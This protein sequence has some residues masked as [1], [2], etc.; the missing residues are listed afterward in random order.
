M[1][2]LKTPKTLRI[3]SIVVLLHA[4][5]VVFSQILVLVGTYMKER[6][7][8]IPEQLSSYVVFPIYFLLPIFILI[9]VY[10]SRSLIQKKYNYLIVLWLAA[11]SVLYFAFGGELY[12]FIHSFHPYHN[13]VN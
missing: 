7:P 4:I 11:F 6:D 8:L 2:K 10:C 3:I 13:S 5:L 12:A 9:I 1:E